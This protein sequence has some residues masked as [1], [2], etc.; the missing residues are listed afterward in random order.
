MPDRPQPIT[1][2]DQAALA[3]ALADWGQ[4]RIPR[5]SNHRM[6]LRQGGDRLGPDDQSSQQTSRQALRRVSLIRGTSVAAS[7]ARA[8]AHGTCTMK[9]AIALGDGHLIENTAGIPQGKRY[10]ICLS[11]QVGCAQGCVFCASGR[12][13]IVRNLETFEIVEQVL[14]LTTASHKPTHVVFMGVGEPLENYDAVSEAIHRLCAPWAFG[15]AQRRITVSSV[16]VSEAIRRLAGDHPQVNF[17]LSLHAADGALR[18]RLVPANRKWPLKNVLEGRSD[19]TR[20]TTRR[21]PTFEYVVLPG[22]NDT[23]QAA[24]ALARTL[25]GIDCTVNL[26]ACH[27]DRQGVEEAPARAFSAALQQ[28][29]L[30]V[31]VRRSRG[32]DVEAACG[33]LRVAVMKESEERIGQKRDDDVQPDAARARRRSRG[34]RCHRAQVP[35]TGGLH[36]ISFSQRLGYGTGRGPGSVSPLIPRARAISPPRPVS[37]PSFIAFSSISATPCCGHGRNVVSLDASA[38]DEGDS[39]QAS[40]PDDAVAF[41]GFTHRTRRAHARRPASRRFPAR[42]PTHGVD[43]LS[44]S[45]PQLPRNRPHAGHKRKGGQVATGAGRAPRL[46]KNSLGTR[47]TSRPNSQPVPVQRTR[48]CL[49]PHGFPTRAR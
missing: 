8:S 29:G 45:I 41:P 22:V 21:Q 42:K 19:T 24:D 33:Q 3:A 32:A 25:A 5:A 26:I 49:Q 31:T 20:R 17:A 4:P 36:G 6:D 14:Q 18:S 12:A 28:R 7:T 27:R 1:A 40:L 37:R 39:L 38:S 15:I 34:L 10:T 30:R 43:S 16:G 47:R 46:R 11:T 35:G 9:L 13:G 2:L 23:P 44:L 48:S